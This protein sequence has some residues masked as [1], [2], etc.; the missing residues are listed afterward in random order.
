MHTAPYRLLVVTTILA[1][2]LN[3]LLP[4][5]NVSVAYAASKPVTESNGRG[6]TKRAPR[7]PVKP[8][9]SPL[10]RTRATKPQPPA[11]TPEIE[12]TK[13]KSS[14]NALFIENVGQFDKRAKFQVQGGGA[15]I[16]LTDNALW[17]SFA[18]QNTHI[19]PRNRARK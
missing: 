8:T 3:S 7:A 18:D 16:F 13:A 9:T 1:L 12:T 17:F 4:L 19:A 5:F 11:N 15:T 6:A 14:S 2:V 10:G